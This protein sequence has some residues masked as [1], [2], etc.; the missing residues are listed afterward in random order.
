MHVLA[1]L[2]GTVYTKMTI[3]LKLPKLFTTY[4]NKV[5]NDIFNAV[6][7]KKNVIYTIRIWKLIMIIIK[8]IP[9][10]IFKKLKL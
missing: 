2:P 5:A 4:P 8:L 3:G 9:E 6:I 1:V 10:E 7:K